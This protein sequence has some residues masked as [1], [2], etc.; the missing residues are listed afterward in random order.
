MGEASTQRVEIASVST[1]NAAM[2]REN[3][4][5]NF[6]QLHTEHTHHRGKITCNTSG[7]VQLLGV[8]FNMSASQRTVHLLVGAPSHSPW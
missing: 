5:L 4:Q 3:V 8:T 2:G 6:G 7:Q 1:N